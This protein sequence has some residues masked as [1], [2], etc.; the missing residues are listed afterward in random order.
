MARTHSGK[1]RVAQRSPSQ[2]VRHH[3]CT[4]ADSLRM[5]HI[6]I[7]QH[8]E[9]HIFPIHFAISAITADTDYLYL[10]DLA[11]HDNKSMLY[12]TEVG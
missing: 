12:P 1:P 3:P 8:S 11:P 7:S 5:S 9:V 10:C 2:P 4:I 6:K